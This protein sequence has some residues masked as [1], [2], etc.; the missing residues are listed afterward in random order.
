MF[1]PAGLR[2]DRC[3]RRLRVT[4][5]V[6]RTSWPG[7]HL[8]AGRVCFEDRLVQTPDRTEKVSVGID[9]RQDPMDISSLGLNV[10][11][12]IEQVAKQE[13]QLCLHA[14][15]EICDFLVRRTTRA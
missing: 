11:R 8:A 14:P 7:P 4:L 15:H 1:D 10:P 5:A 6:V 13:E 9:L 2:H 12:I 3:Y